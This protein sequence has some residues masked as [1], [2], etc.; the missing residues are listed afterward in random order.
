MV[1]QALV[2]RGNVTGMTC[3][4][5]GTSGPVVALSASRRAAP[6]GCH[7]A[8]LPAPTCERRFDPWHMRVNFCRLQAYSIH[9]K[10]PPD[11]GHKLTRVCRHPNEALNM[12][13]LWVL[14]SA[15]SCAQKCPW[16][17]PR[18]LPCQLAC[19]QLPHATL[20]LVCTRFPKRLPK[21]PI[22]PSCT[23]ARH[24]PI[25]HASGE[26]ANASGARRPLPA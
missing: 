2:T 1:R 24:R 26:P 13:C 8:P 11:R 10:G 3:G 22:A 23:I 21:P 15:C 16:G 19:R 5:V 14:A 12:R 18:G 25:A 17:V 6:G 4:F 7:V 20:G 9:S